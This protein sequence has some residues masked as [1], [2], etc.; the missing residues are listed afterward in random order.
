[1]LSNLIFEVWNSFGCFTRLLFHDVKKGF[2]LA[3][4]YVSVVGDGAQIQSVLLDVVGRSTV[5]QVFVNGK[6]IGGSDG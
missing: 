1:M 6:H 3:L 2:V 4:K 5:P